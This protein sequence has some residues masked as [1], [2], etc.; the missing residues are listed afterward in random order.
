MKIIFTIISLLLSAICL[1]F[2][3]YTNYDIYELINQAAGIDKNFNPA[4]VVNNN[5]TSQLGLSLLALA[6][7]ILALLKKQ[8]MG[9]LAII[10]AFISW[11]FVFLPIWIVMFFK[12][13]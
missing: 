9:K 3:A 2:T 11:V 13:H 8:E 10:M 1:V 5:M 4:W 12:S 7:A 6:F